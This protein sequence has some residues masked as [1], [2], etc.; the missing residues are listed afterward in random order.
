[1]AQSRGT[2]ARWVRAGSLALAASLA[3]VQAREVLK[4]NIVYILCDDL[5]YGDVQCLNPQRG[6]IPTPH[7]DR[8]AS[9][10]MT[11][12]AAHSGSAVCTPSR[13]GI[14]TGRY[15]WRTRLQSGVLFGGDGPLIA[16]GRLTVPELL[17]RNGY[18]TACI[19]KWHLGMEFPKG[20][21]PDPA[22]TDPL[23]QIDYGGRIRR[24][25]V[26][27]GFDEY[28]GIS[29]SLDMPPYVYIENDRFAAVPTVVKK[30]IRE[31]PAA[32]DFEA[33]DVLP[34]FTR[35]AVEYIG[36]R[37]AEAQAGKPFFLYLSL[38]SPHT[39]IVPTK[40]WQGK[41][42]IGDYG[43]FVMQTDACVGEIA[44][45]L[46]RAGIAEHTLLVFTSDNGCSPAAQTEDLEKKGHFASA[47][48]RGYKADIWDGGHRIP[49][50]CRW[51]AR[52]KAGSRCDRLTCLT[53]LMA[54]CAEMLGLTLPDDAGEDS[55]SFLPALLGT[56]DRP[57]RENVV[58]H[59]ISGKFA[60]RQG[61]WKLELCSGSGG[62]ARPKDA[63]ATQQGLPDLQLYDMAADVGERRNL[64]AEHPETVQELV[65]RLEKQIADGRSTPGVPQKNDVPI[66][67]WKK[68]PAGLKKAGGRKGHE[69]TE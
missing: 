63:E 34:T 24:G 40:E 15:C 13:Y 28:F 56:S 6:K 9:Q 2:I 62:W 66:D 27:V 45:A 49:L 39:P 51:P 43:D 17:R 8:L 18:A 35:K 42:G 55:V 11:F 4:P 25:P 37:A 58:H 46:E 14:L 23:W 54:T 19:G 20:S 38:N 41:S 57:L 22:R 32:A 44:T 31:G 5:G 7:L 52:V 3:P 68:D 29:A 61:K 47:D 69:A 33:A 48:R 67:L 65:A 36:R 12:T 59:S 10:G 26:A 30:W 50:I 16:E 1:M 53:D 60:I 64:Q 21:A